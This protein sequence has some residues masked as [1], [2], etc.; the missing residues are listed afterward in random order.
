MK[1]L[2]LFI[3]I[4]TLSY[5]SMAQKKEISQAKEYVKKG[6]NLDT[7]E[8][9]MTTLLKDSANRKN[10]KI[11]NVLFDAVSKQYDQGN[12]KLYLKQKYDTASLFIL[13][14]KMFS[15]LESL[16]SLD[17]KP[18]SR[19]RVKLKYRE[20][21]AEFLNGY[22]A[23]L[24]NGGAYFISKHNYQDAYDCFNA[25][26]DCAQQPLFSRYKY[27][28]TDKRIPQA[29]YWAVY[30]GYKLK[31]TKMTLRHTY[32]ALK[33]TS[34]YNYMLQFLADTYKLEDDTVRYVGALTEGF[35]KYPL[36]PYFFPRLIEYYTKKGDFDMA[37]KIA[38][39]ALAV[40]STN[41]VF[42]F[43]K[44]TV[45]LNV[46][47]YAECISICDALIAKNDSLADAYLNAGLAY[48]NQAVE[49]DKMTQASQKRKQKI[50]S[51][52][53]KAMPY[54]QK[55]R[56]L[57]PTQKEKWSIPL[58]TIY[59]NLNMGKEFDEIDKIIR[60]KN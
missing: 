36:F 53:D 29:A 17:M 32:L 13:G 34:H 28:E 59:L 51:Y 16:D 7:A 50:L 14:R 5:A 11:W 9:L 22:R 39:K 12:E 10:E 56:A 40:D 20:K 46:G 43:A 6:T 57:A 25:Y 27:S 30:C 49:L 1:R 38:D 37:M 24:F 52:Y 44:S 60:N 31:D 26:L 23:N 45:L 42:R 33:D 2:L 55:Y 48:F 54:M 4:L 3:F 47:K 19:G 8:K 15:I 21:N 18:D 35:E 58:Y 41:T